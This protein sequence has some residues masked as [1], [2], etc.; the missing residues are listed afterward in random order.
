MT[1]TMVIAPG[2]RNS[3]RFRSRRPK[4]SLLFNTLRGGDP[5]PL[6]VL[7]GNRGVAHLLLIHHYHSRVLRPLV[8]TPLSGFLTQDLPD[9]AD[10]VFL[11]VLALA[12]LL[13][14]GPAVIAASRTKRLQLLDSEKLGF[15]WSGS[16]RKVLVAIRSLARMWME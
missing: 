6:R 13:V 10:L 7:L 15:P 5:Y 2:N 3:G 12:F 11:L 8:V 4:A 1:P 14:Q 16:C 9:L